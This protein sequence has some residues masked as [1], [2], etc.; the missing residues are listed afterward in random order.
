MPVLREDLKDSGAENIAVEIA[1]NIIAYDYRQALQ[2]LN[3][4][5][6]KMNIPLGG[7]DN[8]E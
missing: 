4:L 2:V 7:E 8:E 3:A 5:A 1:R 6:Q